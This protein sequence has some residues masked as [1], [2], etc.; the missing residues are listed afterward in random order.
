MALLVL[1]SAM[2]KL[3]S[4]SKSYEQFSTKSGPV[5]KTVHN[6]TDPNLIDQVTLA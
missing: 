2:E 5:Y 3:I 6:F 1:Q 4:E